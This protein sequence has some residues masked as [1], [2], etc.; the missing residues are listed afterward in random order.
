MLQFT[1]L[2][3][4]YNHLASEKRRLLARLDIFNK[5]WMNSPQAIDLYLFLEIKYLE[6]KVDYL[7]QQRGALST[8]RDSAEHEREAQRARNAS[9]IQTNLLVSDWL[10]YSPLSESINTF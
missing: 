4:I 9:L 8:T 1:D 10:L 6:A 5:G 3:K 7:I 2:Q